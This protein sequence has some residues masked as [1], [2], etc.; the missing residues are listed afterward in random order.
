[1]APPAAVGL[2]WEALAAHAE[3]MDK[4]DGAKPVLCLARFARLPSLSQCPV[5]MCETK[6]KEETTAAAARA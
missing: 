3:T 6:S 1:M 2:A 4:A 5:F